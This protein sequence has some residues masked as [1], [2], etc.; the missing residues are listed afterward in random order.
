V[1]IREYGRS[2]E[3]RTMSITPVGQKGCVKDKSC[4]AVSESDS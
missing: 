4:S 3:P 2:T 1:D